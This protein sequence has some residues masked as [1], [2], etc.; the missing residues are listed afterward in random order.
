MKS[1]NIVQFVLSLTLVSSVGNAADDTSNAAPSEAVAPATG[2]ASTGIS[3]AEARL[4]AALSR[5]V[6]RSNALREAPSPGGAAVGAE[7]RAA[8]LEWTVG[9]GGFALLL[10]LG[11]IWVKKTREARLM[12]GTGVGLSIQESVWVGKGQRLLVVSAGGQ[13]YL[14]GATGGGLETLAELGPAPDEKSAASDEEP[15][16]PATF[17]EFVSQAMNTDGSPRRRRREILDGLRAL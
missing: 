3:A 5:K 7:Q 1:S 10:M 8:V 9:A 16:M 13:R 15:E 6:E 4:A 12:S 11:A 2:D 17:K 14:L